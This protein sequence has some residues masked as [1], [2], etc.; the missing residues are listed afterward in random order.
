[1]T[2]MAHASPPTDMS[3]D[4]TGAETEWHAGCDRCGASYTLTG[5]L[6][7]AMV[8]QVESTW[9]ATHVMGWRE[10]EVIEV[11]QCARCR[12]SLS[13]RRPVD[14]EGLAPQPKAGVG[15]GPKV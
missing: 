10:D 6:R 12:T 13:R 1:M 9:L 3:S 4:P 11:R 8:T 15:R 14:A 7:L 5:W 2:R